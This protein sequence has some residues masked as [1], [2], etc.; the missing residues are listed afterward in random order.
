MRPMSVEDK[1]RTRNGRWRAA[2]AAGLVLVAAVACGSDDDDAS[3]ATD[4]ATG[5]E[6][7]VAV[8]GTTAADG[9][10]PADTVGSSA[11][12]AAEGTAASDGSAPAATEPVGDIPQGGTLRYATQAEP[13]TFD[14]HK[15]A[16]GGDHVSLYPIF[17]RL[18]ASDPETLE[19][20]P[21]LATEWEFTDELTL[22]MT[23]QEGVTFTDG[24]PFNADAVVYNIDRAIN[25]EDSSIK[26]DLSSV[27]SAEA[28]GEYEVVIHLKQP[29]SSLLGVFADRAGM[30]VSPTAAENP[31]F[32]QHPVGTGPHTFESWAPGDKWT[33]G[34][35]ESYWQAGLPYLDNLEFTVLSDVNTRINGLRSGQFDFID[36]LEPLSMDQLEGDD[37]IEVTV[38]PDAARAHDLVEHQPPAARRRARP[39]GHQHGHRP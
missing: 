15:G 11:S 5:T 18:L 35:N 31:D 17:D 21:F 7:T 20:V 26:T 10:A 2:L 25:M 9:T 14:P 36:G 8:E 4:A 13:T 3:S 27:E 24:T 12:T 22:D 1:S 38:E 19:P 34:R 6:A 16:S 28:V 23:L 32:G 30:M 39:P 29:D 37:A 33:Y